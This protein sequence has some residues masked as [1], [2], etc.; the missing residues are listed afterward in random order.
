MRKQGLAVDK[1]SKD[2]ALQRVADELKYPDL[3]SM[4]VAIGEGR[5]TTQSVTTRVLRVAEPEPQDDPVYEL[6]EPAPRRS[7][8]GRAKGV[9]VEGHDDL[10]VRLARCCTPVPGDPIVGFLTRGRG[11]SVHREDCPNV[12]SLKASDEGRMSSVWWDDTRRTTFVAAIQVE[13]LDRTRLLRDVT[14]AISDQ[15]IQILS[16]TTR[17][18]KDGIAVLAFSLELADPSHLQ[19]ILRS[20]RRIDSVFDAYRVV[21]PAARV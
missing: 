8:T 3:D 19:H 15:G 9:I 18:G 14:S 17:T 20:V 5:L 10:L 13:A 12:T 16:S 7:P 1:I 2:G 6:D 11:V 21:S 4:Y